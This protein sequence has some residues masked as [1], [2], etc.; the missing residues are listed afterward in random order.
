MQFVPILIGGIPL[1]A[2]VMQ[3]G[4]AKPLSR[5]VARTELLNSA[6]N[7]SVPRQRNPFEIPAQMAATAEQDTPNEM[8][9][10]APSSVK[11]E[12]NLEQVAASTFLAATMINGERKLALIAGKVY[13]EGMSLAGDDSTVVI[14]RIE[15]DQVVIRKGD[16]TAVIRYA[17]STSVRNDKSQRTTSTSTRE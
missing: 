13:R 14:S 8:I 11:T 1:A 16:Q 10:K 4:N 12:L 6:P 17:G 9:V 2:C 15:D 5:P 7:D 3:E